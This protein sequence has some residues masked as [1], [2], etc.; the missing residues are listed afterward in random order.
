MELVKS[1]TTFW[2]YVKYALLHPWHV[3]VIAGATIFGVAS[4]SIFVLFSVFIL[5]ELIMLVVITRLGVFRK[6]VDNHILKI[7]RAKASEIRSVLLLQMMDEHRRE[8][9][10]LESRV[11]I[12]RARLASFPAISSIAADECM[13]LLAQYVRIA[14][15]YNLTLGAGAYVTL[16]QLND[17]ITALEAHQKIKADPINEQ[18][19]AIAQRRIDI[20]LSSCQV[21]NDMRNQLAAI[22]ELVELKTEQSVLPSA[23][24]NL[25]ALQFRV[26]TDN[27]AEELGEFAHVDEMVAT[28]SP[29]SL[30]NSKSIVRTLALRLRP[31]L[32]KL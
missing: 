5:A 30:K 21:R 14:I 29:L 6:Y 24:N 3:V 4:W 15:Q 8:L 28:Q 23:P 12:L 11:D 2:T 10:R 27:L 25:P 1:K 22:S 17:Q 16:Q 20:L 18:R 7:D 19:I 26:D 13:E 31:S 32:K 9:L